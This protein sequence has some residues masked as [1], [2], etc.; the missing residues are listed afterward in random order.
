[1]EN[2]LRHAIVV[3]LAYL[4]GAF[5]TGFLAVR[6]FRGTDVRR[7]GSGRTGST[8]VLRSAGALPAL[9]TVLGDAFKGGLAILLARAIGGTPLALALAGVATILGHNYSVFL[10]FDGGAGTITTIGVALFVY[11]PVGLAAIVVGIA[12]IVLTRYASLAS[13]VVAISLPAFY[14]MA[15]HWGGKPIV[16]CLY[17]AIT[18]LISIFELRPNILRLLAGTERKVALPA[19][20]PLPARK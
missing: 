4:L 11:P 14:W 15:A 13:I 19:Q 6:A 7:V 8:N 17:A 18:G 10:S 3:P 1:M 16:F 9:L 2:V 5:P 20:A 12:T